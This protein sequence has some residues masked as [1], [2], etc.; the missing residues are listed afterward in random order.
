MFSILSLCVTLKQ[1][2]PYLTH[3]DA[4]PPPITHPLYFLSSSSFSIFFSKSS[5]SILDLSD[6]G[7][8]QALSHPL[9]FD[10]SSSFSIIYSQS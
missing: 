7:S 3:I 4:S 9:C 8:L 5:N 2:K 10:S 1:H 6:L